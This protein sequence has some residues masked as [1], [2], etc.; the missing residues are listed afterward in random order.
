MD[1]KILKK[2]QQIYEKQDVLSKLINDDLYSKIGYSELHCLVTIHGL[3]EP[4]LTELSNHMNMTLGAISK[5]VKKLQQKKLIEVIQ[6]E[7]NKKEKYLVL[8]Q[9]GVLIYKEHEIAHKKWEERD[10]TF[11]M[12]IKESDK[13]IISTF[14]DSFNEYLDQLIKEC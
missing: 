3:N 1:S 14:L 11:L 4:N 9:E 8:N 13:K 12:T 5:I 10:N 2:F 7:N 6:K